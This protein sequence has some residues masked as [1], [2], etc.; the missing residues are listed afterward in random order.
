MSFPSN[1]EKQF[2]VIERLPSGKILECYRVKELK[3][4]GKERIL[5]LLPANLAK[6][7]NMVEEFHRFFTRFSEISNRKHIPKVYSVAGD[8]GGA[9][10]VLEEYFQ[11]IPLPQYAESIRDSQSFRKDI[12]KVLI[13]VCEALHH[14]HQKEIFHLCIR[15]ED[16][17]ISLKNPN[18]VKLLGF[19]MQVFTKGNLDSL[20]ARSRGY[21]PAEVLEG[22]PFNAS[23]DIY[24]LAVVI[25]ECL[26]TVVTDRVILN[27]ARSKNPDNRFP[28]ARDFEAKL[29]EASET[30]QGIARWLFSSRKKKSEPV[31]KI[32]LT[33]FTLPPRVDIKA[34][35]KL[36]GT[37]SAS[38]LTVPWEPGLKLVLERAGYHSETLTFP[39]AP[40][41]ERI[42]V[43]LQ[44]IS[45]GPRPVTPLELKQ[46]KLR[47]SVS[48]GERPKGEVPI[49]L[50]RKQE[51]SSSLS[52]KWVARLIAYPLVAGIIAGSVTYFMY[53][54]QQAPTQPPAAQTPVVTTPAP[55]APPKPSS[56]TKHSIPIPPTI[57]NPR[58]RSLVLSG[59]VKMS[60]VI[61]MVDYVLRFTNEERSQR[62]LAPFQPSAVLAFI[63]Q[64]HSENMCE[65]RIMENDSISFPD[66]WKN[67]NERLGLF[68]LGTGSENIASL[69][70]QQP[71][72]LARQLVSS[73][74]NNPTHRD[75][76]VNPGWLYIGIGVCP[77][78]GGVAYATQVFS[79]QEGVLR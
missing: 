3:L 51:G 30:K 23:S 65:K 70:V 69:T 73:W 16:I 66:G 61:D 11:G 15:P 22:R 26:P 63:A 27:T 14:A 77:C 41:Q 35:G 79:D 5:R 55:A 12:V 21:V 20:P 1:L 54:R 6:N 34:K 58:S 31:P 68:N 72:K 42:T 67:L 19:G 8:T 44:T 33:I 57:K 2:Q 25:N 13:K 43:R 10:Y 46:E 4:L 36:L 76:I 39:T 78:S 52:L 18:D 74:M 49:E 37:T 64:V 53:G 48:S 24:S 17:R 29:T 28:T 75:N 50:S 47:S 56:V 62:G 9:V 71:E 7:A 45:S 32:L 40:S 59:N 38:G 60:E